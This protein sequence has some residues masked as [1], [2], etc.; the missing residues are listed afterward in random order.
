MRRI[1]SRGAN[2]V[3]GGDYY[4]ADDAAKLRAKLAALTLEKA[5]AAENP[6]SKLVW[7]WESYMYRNDVAVKAEIDAFTP[8][9][10]ARI[11]A[12]KGEIAENLRQEL[13]NMSGFTGMGVR[14]G[15]FTEESPLVKA[16]KAALEATSSAVK[17]Y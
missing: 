3:H 6:A 15:M 16:V 12:W 2:T 13:S 9:Y 11:S 1:P 7:L 4:N 5:H 8:Q 14:N 10:I 17:H